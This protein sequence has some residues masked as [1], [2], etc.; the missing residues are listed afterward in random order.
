[1]RKILEFTVCKLELRGNEKKKKKIVGKEPEMGYCPF[2]HWLGR[3]C[4]LGA[5]GEGR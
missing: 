1:M 4:R 2:D 5:H 3:T